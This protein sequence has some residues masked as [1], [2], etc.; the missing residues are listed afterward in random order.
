MNNDSQHEERLTSLF[1]RV[2]MRAMTLPSLAE[3][4]GREISLP[5]LQCLRYLHQQGELK[6]GEISEGL[7]ISDPAASKLVDRL[8]KK[9][10][11]KRR[12][13]ATDRRASRVALTEEGFRLIEGFRE[14]RSARLEA[15]LARMEPADRRA[16]ITGI[17]RFIEAALTDEKSLRGAC[18]RCGREH[19][20]DCILNRKYQ[21]MTGNTILSNRGG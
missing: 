8:E 10:L 2:M 9:G 16:L 7:A 17:E 13:C 21:A 19:D 18:L 1:S 11:V 14:R 12:P 5:Q 3:A 15:V 4:N 20:L 6:M